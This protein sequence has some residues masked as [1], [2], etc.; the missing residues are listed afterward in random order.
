MV[1]G[2]SQTNKIISWL[3]IFVTLKNDIVLIEQ[4]LNKML[5]LM[6]KFL[7]TRDQKN[8]SFRVSFQFKV[9]SDIRQY[10]RQ[11]DRFLS[12]W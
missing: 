8:T 11:N 7:D 4:S 12:D 5:Q 2:F 9:M 10:H 1:N 3:V 6:R